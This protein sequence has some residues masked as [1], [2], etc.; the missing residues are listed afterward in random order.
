MCRYCPR[1]DHR[2][3]VFLVALT[4]YMH[5]VVCIVS[6]WLSYNL[7]QPVTLKNGQYIINL[8]NI[9]SPAYHIILQHWYTMAATMFKLWIQKVVAQHAFNIMSIWKQRMQGGHEL[10]LMLTREMQTMLFYYYEIY[11]RIITN[12]EQYV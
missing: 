2:S 4:K 5:N 8:A 9:T 12:K 1:L 3:G 6:K 11:Y 10:L 7:S